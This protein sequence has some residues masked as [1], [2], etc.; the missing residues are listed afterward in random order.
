MNPP[1]PEAAPAAPPAPRRV[2]AVI[3]IGSVSARMQ[4]AEVCGPGEV[5]TLDEL[6]RP[7]QL[8]KDTFS[9]GR[10]RQPTIEEAVKVLKGFRRVM[11]EYGVDPAG[12]RAVATSSVREA[13]NRDTFLD[14]VYMATQINVEA[15]DEAEETR[16]T[17]LA[18]QGILLREPELRK[19]NALVL[20]VGGGDSELL[21]VQDGFVTYSNTFR[22]GTLRLREALDSHRAPAHR[23]A[24]LLAKQ[25]EVVAD[26]MKRSVPA[27]RAPNLVALSGDAR[28]AA[29]HLVPK[30]QS[31]GM[32]RVDAKA[33]AAF[34]K[35]IAPLGADELVKSYRLSYQEADTVGPALIAFA[36]VARV[37][38][39]DTLFISKFSLR[40]GL[41]EEVLSGGGGAPGFA[42]QVLHSAAALGAKYSFDE[43]H[44]RQ[45]AELSVH[46]FRA[47]KDEH[48][49]APRYE[50]ILRL[51][52]MLHELGLFISNRSH[53]KHSMYLILNSE[54][55]GVGRRD[56]NLIGLIARYHRKASPQPYHEVFAT[57]SREDRMIV[58]KLAA[59]LRVADA[60]DRN[61]M[62]QVRDLECTRTE[63][64]FVIDVR[65]VEDLTLERMAL[66]EK[67]NLFE[68]TYGMKVILRGVSGA[69]RVVTDA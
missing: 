28:F 50:V 62:Q 54:L 11:D 9:L 24:P 46:L 30:W 32:A 36:Q 34:A 5:R 15:I 8:G 53:H 44:G 13:E 19:G 67:G 37:F 14:R 38:Q 63:D 66:K 6:E 65:D 10:I 23:V 35:K 58:T 25:I 64:G 3:D 68:E 41:L 33:F 31:L 60:L 7:V 51:A 55:F 56:L 47:L 40:N 2:V 39:S 49:L 69:E 42:E 43:R 18:V 27:A 52:A 17:Y 20:E 16:L 45:V 1:V 26:Q 12:V 4:I 59:I 48:R 29:S 61:H 57:L 22:L 21:L